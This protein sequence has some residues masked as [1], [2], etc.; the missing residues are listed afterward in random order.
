[1]KPPTQWKGLTWTSIAVGVAVAT[2]TFFGVRALVGPDPNVTSRAPEPLVGAWVT[3]EPR[4][5]G[6][7]FVVHPDEYHVA[8]GSDSVLMYALKEVR[9]IEQSEYDAYQVTYH[10]RDG[11]TTQEIHLYPDGTARL[12]NPSDVV[13]RR[14]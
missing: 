9:R 5:A 13:W 14:R 3:E 4:Y 11:E 1:M 10:T 8:I 6:R 7:A 12:R 2:A